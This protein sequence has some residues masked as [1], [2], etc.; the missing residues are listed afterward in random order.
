MKWCWQ[1]EHLTLYAK[2]ASAVCQGNGGIGTGT[3]KYQAVAAASTPTTGAAA[4]KPP[5]L[6]KPCQWE[7]VISP[8]SLWR[9]SCNFHRIGIGRM[10]E[11]LNFS[12]PVAVAAVATGAATVLASWWVNLVHNCTIFL[13]SLDVTN[14]WSMQKY[15]GERSSRRV[16]I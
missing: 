16:T 5:Y 14:I 15:K 1:T 7:I 3:P 9:L 12:H 6:D 2:V 13:C 10:T 8:I 4:T 11:G